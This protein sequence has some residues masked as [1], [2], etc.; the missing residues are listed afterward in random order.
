MAQEKLYG[1]VVGQL[2]RHVKDK[3][4]ECESIMKYAEKFDP[5]LSFCFT[6][7]EHM[8]LFLNQYEVKLDNSKLHELCFYMREC[9]TMNYMDI[10]KCL[11]PP[12]QLIENVIKKAIDNYSSRKEFFEAQTGGREFWKAEDVSKFMRTLGVRLEDKEVS[13]V[14]KEWSGIN[15]R[16]SIK[17]E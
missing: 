9:S 5:E 13:E 3:E 16:N 6:D 4:I 10:I 8:K 12:K 7:Y 2:A 14:V 17:L 15:K 1:E 11:V